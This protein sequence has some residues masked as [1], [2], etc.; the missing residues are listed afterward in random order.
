MYFLYLCV[1][2]FFFLLFYLFLQNTL[3]S[4]VVHSWHTEGRT[5]NCKIMESTQTALWKKRQADLLW[6]PMSLLLRSISCWALRQVHTS[7]PMFFTP[8]ATL[9]SWPI[10]MC[11]PSLPSDFLQ[12]THR[13]GEELLADKLWALFSNC[14][15]SFLYIM[16]ITYAGMDGYLM[17]LISLDWFFFLVDFKTII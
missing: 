3:Q 10:C 11:L 16:P 4:S 14:F 8:Q 15:C 9:Q 17:F 5:Q 6:C 2:V 1:C 13:E 12:W 7:T